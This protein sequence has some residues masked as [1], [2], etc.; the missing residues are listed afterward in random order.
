MTKIIQ[1]AVISI[2]LIPFN[3][4]VAQTDADYYFD[5]TGRMHNGYYWEELLKDD[6]V[7]SRAWTKM[8]WNIWHDSTSSPSL[9]EGDFAF[10]YLRGLYDEI[11]GESIDDTSVIRKGFTTLMYEDTARSIE[12]EGSGDSVIS[13]ETNVQVKRWKTIM[14]RRAFIRGSYYIDGVNDGR[15]GL[16]SS[17]LGQWHD[18]LPAVYPCPR[19][20]FPVESIGEFYNNIRNLVVPIVFASEI[21][22]MKLK[23]VS[24]DTVQILLKRLLNKSDEMHLPG[25]R[26]TEW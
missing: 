3:S 22:L 10:C 7:K 25:R 4:L 11:L 1:Y 26:M 20:T 15:A 18:L 21:C 24:A 12:Y 2:V 8:G 14:R 17:G 6:S 5:N 13:A 23:H 9:W 16:A 19:S